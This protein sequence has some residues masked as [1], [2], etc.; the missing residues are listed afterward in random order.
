MKPYCTAVIVVAGNSTRMGGV[1]KQFLPLLGKPA[2]FYTLT[3]FA[4]TVCIDAIVLVGKPEHKERLFA[5]AEQAG[6]K[7][8]LY[9]AVGGNSRQQSVLSGVSAAPEQTQYVA[10]HDGARPLITPALISQAVTFAA[11]YGAAAL[12]VSVKDTVKVVDSRGFV[13]A[14]PERSALRAVQTPQVFLRTSY[15]EAAQAALQSRQEYTDDCA[16]LEAAGKSVYLCTGSY[17]N[18]KLTTP[19]DCLLAEILLQRREGLS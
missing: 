19:E 2:L 15:L 8:S 18:I 17:E 1:P 6:M 7:K 4:Q 5:C 12:S 16:L 9:F 3:A 10:I 11:E 14:T 13:S